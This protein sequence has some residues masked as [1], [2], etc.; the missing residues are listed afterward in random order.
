MVALEPGSSVGPMS[1]RRVPFADIRR[2]DW[3]RLLAVT[4]AA[5]PFTRWTFHRAWWDAY[6]EDAEDCY[7]EV[8]RSRSLADARE[9]SSDRVVI[10]IVPLMLRELPMSR[11]PRQL[12][13][14]ASYHADYATV[15]SGASDLPDVV[16]M[17]VHQLARRGESVLSWD[18]IDLRRLRGDDPVSTALHAA[19][20]AQAREHGWVVHGEIEDV[21]PVVPLADDWTGQLASMTPRARHE[22]RRKLR[23]A[24]RHGR[25]RLR[26]LPLTGASATRFIDLHQARWGANGLFADTRIGHRGRRFMHRLVELEGAEGEVASLHL[27]EVTLGDDTIYALAGFAQDDTCYFYNAGLAP[28]ALELSPGVVGTAL[29]LRDRLETG[30]RAFDFLRGDEDY[31]RSW[32]AVEEAIHRIVVERT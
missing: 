9:S 32:G 26:Y 7:L 13:M 30:D 1:I 12:F 3:D 2:S 29:Y 10:G 4:P 11:T 24:E 16:D 25:L 19:L 18:I 28:H 5:T 27:G 14:A 20:R 8:S 21:C 22:V 15:L 31:K 23:R 17:A 6:G